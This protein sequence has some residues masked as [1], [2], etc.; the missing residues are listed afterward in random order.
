M[1]CGTHFTSIVPDLET[2]RPTKRPDHER[3]S[4]DY[5][6]LAEFPS[7][8]LIP[9][10]RT[11]VENI[12]TTKN[13][14]PDP[15][16]IFWS[17]DAA[18]ALLRDS[19]QAL[20]AGLA[21]LRIDYRKDDKRTIIAE[22]ELFHALAQADEQLAAL[23]EEMQPADQQEMIAEESAFEQLR[24]LQF[25]YRVEGFYPRVEGLLKDIRA[26]RMMARQP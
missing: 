25:A 6:R 11:T 13:A 12:T 20:S 16:S 14:N 26:E 10:L 1:H 17:C 22:D 21:S 9:K 24:N 23:L 19:A 18:L 8:S 7:S 2:S 3:Q 15:H 5:N 4:D